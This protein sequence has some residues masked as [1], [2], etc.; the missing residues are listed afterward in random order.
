MSFTKILVLKL[1]KFCWDFSCYWA[2]IWYY[3]NKFIFSWCDTKVLHLQK[4]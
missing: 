4:S 2:E 3:W 1:P